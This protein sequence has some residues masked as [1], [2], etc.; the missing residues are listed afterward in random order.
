MSLARPARIPL[1][2]L[3]IALLPS[4]SGD[5]PVEPEPLVGAEDVTF[6]AELGVDLGRMTRLE[7]GVYVEDLDGPGDP[8]AAEVRPLFFVWVRYDGWLS[9]GTQVADG[10]QIADE[11]IGA[12]NFISGWDLGLIGAKQGGTRR[13]VIPPAR[14]YGHQGSGTLIP[15]NA[16]LVFDI[17]IDSVHNRN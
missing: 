3:V 1:L 8:D 17:Q 7:S 11:Q 5:D 2:A 4:C 13:L 16:V 10:A 9:D 6:A 12:G 15:P 14:A